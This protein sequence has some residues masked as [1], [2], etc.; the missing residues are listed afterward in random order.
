[1]DTTTDY[2]ADSTTPSPGY[3]QLRQMKQQPTHFTNLGQQPLQQHQNATQ[4]QVPRSGHTYQQQQWAP[5]QDPSYAAFAEPTPEQLAAAHQSNAAESMRNLLYHQADEFVKNTFKS[6]AFNLGNQASLPIERSL[7]DIGPR[8]H[9]DTFGLP[10]DVSSNNT[11]RPRSSQSMG[12]FRFPSTVPVRPFTPP[13]QISDSSTASTPFRSATPSH[14]VQ[15]E[16]VD[17]LASLAESPDGSVKYGISNSDGFEDFFDS[18]NADDHRSRLSK[19]SSI[20]LSI[21]PSPSRALGTSLSNLS[22][23]ET[24]ARDV[25]LASTKNSIK[26]SSPEPSDIEGSDD[27][28]G[29]IY[30]PTGVTDEELLSHL[31]EDHSSEKYLLRCTW[32]ECGC[33]FQRTENGKSHIQTHLG[34]RPYHCPRC[35]KRFTRVHDCKRHCRGHS[36]EKVHKCPCGFQNARKD[37]LT[38]HQERVIC[39][40]VQRQRPDIVKTPVKRGRPKK[41]RPISIDEGRISKSSPKK[42]DRKRLKSLEVALSTHIPVL[43][44]SPTLRCRSPTRRRADA[45]L[46][47]SQHNVDNW[48]VELQ[49][50]FPMLAPSAGPDH[51]SDENMY[52]PIESNCTA[53]NATVPS[54]NDASLLNSKVNFTPPMSPTGPFSTGFNS[55]VKQNQHSNSR[56]ETPPRSPPELSDSP[57][58]SSMGGELP[59][60]YFDAE[61]E[62]ALFADVDM[63]LKTVQDD[64]TQDCMYVQASM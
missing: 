29:F 14:H 47:P 49:P 8:S 33:T 45:S 37:A 30:I 28:P 64:N 15:S 62:S 3:Q 12:D 24:L 53:P 31:A 22:F 20:D 11:Q 32:P 55:P 16:A 60:S 52:S 2:F 17:V 40:Y 34:D 26:Q 19:G 13:Q 21:N 9:T 10:N 18:A 57:A 54:F 23:E 58:T 36:P 7:S 27:E 43:G 59:S 50:S 51:E 5:T 25:V 38:R 48:T 1:M 63:L 61:L 41:L 46:P 39:E 35:D 56:H 4:A 6:L 42:A 44:P